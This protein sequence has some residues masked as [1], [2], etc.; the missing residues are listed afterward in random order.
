MAADSSAPP[1]AGWTKDATPRRA[2]FR[3]IIEAPSVSI[4]VVIITFIG[5]GALARDMGFDLAQAIFV[6]ATVFALPGQVVLADQ[7]GQSLP[8]LAAFLGVTLTAVR[9]LPLTASLLPNLRG[10]N[11][12]RWLQYLLSHFIAVTIWVESMRRLPPIPRELRVPYYMGFAGTLFIANLLATGLGFFLAST[13]S[14]PVAAALIFLT[15][16]YFLL[17]LIAVSRDL[18]DSLALGIGFVLGPILFVFAPGFDLALTG[19]IGGT[20]AYW[21]LRRRER[22]EAE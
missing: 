20:I 9:L 18:S 15:P 12:P 14:T 7:V 22:K 10:S 8:L 17:A 13:V 19:L 1:Q 4:V 3:G 16:V 5:F 11:T 6:S 2:F 21:A